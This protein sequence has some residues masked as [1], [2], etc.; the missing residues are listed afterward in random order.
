MSSKESSI[1]KKIDKLEISGSDSVVDLLKEKTPWI[2]GTKFKKPKI[3]F[4]NLSSGHRINL[5]TP[6]KAVGLIL[7]YIILFILQAGFLYIIYRTP[8]AIG[9]NQEGKAIFFFPGVHDQYIM[10]GIVA[11]I[12]IFLASA[13]YILLYQA[14]KYIYDR[15]MA[16]KILA[17]GFILIIISFIT[18]QLMLSIKTQVLKEFLRSLLEIY[19]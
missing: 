14:S 8:P 15:T 9:S 3:N 7:I 17:I 4:P 2:F 18:L 19:G 16:I 12:V 6:S 13:G 10:E 11:S 1:K 5:P